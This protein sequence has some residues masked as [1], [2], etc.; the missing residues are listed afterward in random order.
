MAVLI[1][2]RVTGGSLITTQLSD[3]V[4][5]LS[6]HSNNNQSPRQGSFIED[7]RKGWFSFMFSFFQ[8]Y[9]LD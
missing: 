7:A 1:S 9:E 2:N 6:L 4:T 5:T 3:V 8:I